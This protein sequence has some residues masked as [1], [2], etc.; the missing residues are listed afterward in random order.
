VAGALLRAMRGAIWSRRLDDG[1]VELG[2][3]LPRFEV[4]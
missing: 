4:A 2:F 1:L 3:S